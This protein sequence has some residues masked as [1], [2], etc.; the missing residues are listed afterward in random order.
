[1]KVNKIMQLKK[2]QR[3]HQQITQWKEMK[4]NIGQQMYV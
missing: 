4:Q 1:M 2:V 3:K